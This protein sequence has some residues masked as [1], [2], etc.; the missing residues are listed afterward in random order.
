MHAFC[1]LHCNVVYWSWLGCLYVLLIGGSP[2]TGT[3]TSQTFMAFTVDLL[4]MSPMAWEYPLCFINAL[5][6]G[7]SLTMW[8]P[9]TEGCAS[10]V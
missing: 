6:S 9:S 7:T 8:P 1:S 4:Y 10:P 2:K 5:G 3:Q